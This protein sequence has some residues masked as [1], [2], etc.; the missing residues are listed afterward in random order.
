MKVIATTAALEKFCAEAMTARYVT[1][2]TE[3]M[4][5]NT[6]YPKLC[7][8]QIASADDAVLV[9]PLADGID[10]APV[11][12]L[13][14]APQVLKVFHAARQDIEIF[15]HLSG[16]VPA[17]IFDTQIAGMVCGFGDAISYDRLVKSVVGVEIDKS[18]RFTD[19]ARRPL[20]DRQLTYALSDVTH[21]RL[22][23]EALEERLRANGREPWLA[24]EMAV[25][26]DPATYVVAPE[27]AWRRLKLRNPK[28]RTLAVLR[29]LAALRENEA[30]RRDLPRN[31]VLRDEVL[32]E[33]AASVP[34]TPEELARAR[35]IS[36][37]VAKGKLGQGILE[38]VRRGANSDRNSWPRPPAATPPRR[39][40]EPVVEL[41]RVLL[42]LKAEEHGVAQKLIANMADLDLIA[43]D[44]DADVPALSGWR[45][46]IFG[47]A[48]IALKHGGVALTIRDGEIAP[49]TL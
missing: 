22:V 19:W 39:G 41:L 38:A 42:K 21:L 37:N 43:D 10:L 44:D 32:T 16:A 6:Y 4:R 30:R 15:V 17:P 1:V 46:E 40:R 9:D 26:T 33:I 25:L 2:D 36:D 14:A 34:S 11:F 47:D 12:A 48:A 13:M 23:F 49:I 18:S 31:R 3:F 24:D 27:D 35:S 45:R 28:P 7:L 20:G 5:E 29:E 8:L